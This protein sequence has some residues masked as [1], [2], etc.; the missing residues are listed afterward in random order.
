[1]VLCLWSW[2]LSV[3]KQCAVLQGP[4]GAA[5]PKSCAVIYLV[6]KQCAGGWG[7]GVQVVWYHT[8]ASGV[9]PEP[10]YIYLI[11]MQCAGG[12]GPAL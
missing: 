6:Y 3:H 11:Y 8:G 1:M 12:V 2:L 5:R 7:P 4:A 9:V 10:F